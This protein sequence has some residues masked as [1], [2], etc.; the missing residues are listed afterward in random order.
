MI[1]PPPQYVGRSAYLRA[2]WPGWHARLWQHRG[3]HWRG[4]DA[5]RIGNR[6]GIHLGTH[7]GCEHRL[8]ASEPGE[9]IHALSHLGWGIQVHDHEDLT[10][11]GVPAEG[12]WVEPLDNVGKHGTRPFP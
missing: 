5:L 9:D 4:H 12:L 8:S 6:L 10:P 1:R 3:L 11:R 2:P 7:H